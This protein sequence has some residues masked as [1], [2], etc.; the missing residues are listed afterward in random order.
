MIGICPSGIWH[1]G[2]CPGV[3]VQGYMSGGI[4]PGVF[5]LIPTGVCLFVC[6]VGPGFD[7]TFPAFVKKKAS[8][9]ARSDDKNQESPP[10]PISGGR[11]C[12]DTICANVCSIPTSCMMWRFINV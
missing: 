9:T 4:C 3:F 1:G 2:Y 10:P 11:G 5:V 8:Q 6:V 12:E 7:S